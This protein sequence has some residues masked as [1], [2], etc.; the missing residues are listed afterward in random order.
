MNKN[1][2]TIF[3]LIA[4]LVLI[5][6][7]TS[8]FAQTTGTARTS[9]SITTIINKAD[10]EIDQ[11]VK[12]LN[13]I[14]ARIGSMTK[15]TSNEQNSLTSSVQNEI[16]QLTALKAKIDGDTSTPTARTDYQTITKS[17]RIYLLVLPQTRIIAASDRALA[18]IDSMNIIG[19]KVQTRV[20]T[21]T[22]TNVATINQILADFTAKLGDASTLAK[23]ANDEVSGLQ[24]DQ[25]DKT[26]A[27][28]N[29]TALKDARTK[30]GTVISDLIAA[31]KDIGTIVQDLK[32]M[33]GAAA[34]NP[35]SK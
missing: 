5:L 33:G 20:A 19:G 15:I 30:I 8:V 6:A 2:N 1:F 32:E 4:G 31:R 21:L 29:A 18:I 3:L 13:E 27:Q 26:K 34:A 22:G 17:Y 10:K 11:R 7:T 9:V 24:P 23:A 16:N 35:S 25:G 14:L 28:S 12:F